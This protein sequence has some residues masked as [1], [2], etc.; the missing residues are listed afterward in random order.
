[1]IHEKHKD[2]RSKDKETD[3]VRTVDDK[4][5]DTNATFAGQGG[6]ISRYLAGHKEAVDVKGYHDVRAP[7]KNRKGEFLAQGYV[8][9]SEDDPDLVLVGRAGKEPKETKD[10][11]TVQP[12]RNVEDEKKASK[13][14]EKNK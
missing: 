3:N 5:T 7:Q 6:S 10:K 1:M 11:N 4:V 2:D 8:I 13:S 14:H 12:E 9:L